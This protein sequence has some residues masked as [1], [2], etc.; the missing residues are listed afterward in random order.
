MKQVMP[1][2]NEFFANSDAASESPEPRSRSWPMLIAVFAL[3]G[4]CAMLFFFKPGQYWFYPVC[5][6]YTMTGLYCPGC[7]SS[8]ALHELLHGNLVEAMRLNALLLLGLAGS[9]WLLA[10]YAWARM[11]RRRAS[12]AVPS[13]WLWA[14]LGV[15]VVF[16]FLRNL[17]AFSWLAPP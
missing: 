16:T 13:R 1:M 15:A 5:H 17:P 6:F 14:L 11:H 7:G 2:Q 9:A 12:F 8:R 10:R 4:A 3:A